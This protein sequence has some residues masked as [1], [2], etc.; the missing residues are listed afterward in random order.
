MARHLSDNRNLL[1]KNSSATFLRESVYF[2]TNHHLE[3]KITKLQNY[4]KKLKQLKNHKIKKLKTEI[5]S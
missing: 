4:F 2:Y 5:K 1:N 3:N